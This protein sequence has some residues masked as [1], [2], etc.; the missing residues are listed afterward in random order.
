MA[1]SLHLSALLSVFGVFRGTGGWRLETIKK[2]WKMKDMCL[3]H[4]FAVLES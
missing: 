2:C 4:V 3:E 1:V